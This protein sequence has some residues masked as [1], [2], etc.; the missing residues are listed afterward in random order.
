MGYRCYLKTT[1]GMDQQTNFGL[2]NEEFLEERAHR[3]VEACLA[4]RNRP[5]GKFPKST[6]R[7]VY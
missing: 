7:N 6:E 3:Q 1:A 5:W 4:I 2:A